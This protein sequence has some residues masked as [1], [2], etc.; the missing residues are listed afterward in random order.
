MA[1][2]KPTIFIAFGVSLL[3]LNLTF[4]FPAFWYMHL[5]YGDFCCVR[6]SCVRVWGLGLQFLITVSLVSST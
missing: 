5:V 1:L 2:T 4:Q 3:H 6:C